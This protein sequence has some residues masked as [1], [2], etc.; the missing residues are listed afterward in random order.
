[1]LRKK[2]RPFSGPI[3]NNG[4][5]PPYDSLASVLVKLDEQVH[6]PATFRDQ[7]PHRSEELAE[8]RAEVASVKAESQQMVERFANEL[9]RLAERLAEL[10]SRAHRPWWARIFGPSVQGSGPASQP[11]QQAAAR[12]RALFLERTA[13]YRP[14]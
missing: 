8:L 1:M 11:R 13:E 10:E 4:L 14:T 7:A 3:I 6:G 12:L 2:R 9:N 5:A